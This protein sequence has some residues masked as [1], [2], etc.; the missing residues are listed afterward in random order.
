[1]T[2]QEVKEMI[3]KPPYDKTYNVEQYINAPTTKPEEVKQLCIDLASKLSIAESIRNPRVLQYPDYVND[4]A[5]QMSMT[6][7]DRLAKLVIYTHVGQTPE[8]HYEIS[9]WLQKVT[10]RWAIQETAADV[11]ITLYIA[12]LC[13]LRELTQD[14]GDEM[15]YQQDKPLHIFRAI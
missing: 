14:R 13:S 9:E 4:L 10:N 2:R 12:G 3:D 8:G 1:M 6:L 11:L 5:N 7:H 15:K